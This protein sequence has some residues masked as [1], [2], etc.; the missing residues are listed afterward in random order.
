MTEP[1]F[2]LLINHGANPNLADHGFNTPLFI[3]CQ[4]QNI[5]AIHKLL[6]HGADINARDQ[7]KNT[8]LHTVIMSKNLEAIKI[9]LPFSPKLNLKNNDKQTPLMLAKTYL[10][11]EPEALSL[12]E[13]LYLYQKMNKLP[14]QI[15]IAKKNKNKI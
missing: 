1:I 14:L 10:T 12:I 9:L 4:K 2:N 3:A 6:Q 13:S 8:P 15:S 5:P 7:Y 11:N